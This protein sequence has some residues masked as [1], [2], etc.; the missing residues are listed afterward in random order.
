MESDIA[1]ILTALALALPGY[2]WWRKQR[3]V[4]PNAARRYALGVA[5]L[6]VSAVAITFLVA[7][8]IPDGGGAAAM[9]AIA[10]LLL[11]MAAAVSGFL[12]WA[13]PPENRRQLSP[14]TLTR[15]MLLFVGAGLLAL[16][17]SNWV[18]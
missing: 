12:L 7:L 1:R 17:A 3:L 8:A 2:F 18:L 11:F 14:S 5:A 6:A 16:A 4:N 13:V 15:S 9:A 10:A